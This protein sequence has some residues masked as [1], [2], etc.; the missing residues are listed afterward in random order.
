MRI[1]DGSPRQ[2]FEE[3]LRS[4]GAFLDE[5]GMRDIL[6]AET[7]DGF[8]VQALVVSGGTTGGW[9]EQLGTLTK[10]SLTLLDEDVVRLMDEG[11]ARRQG[12]A[13]AAPWSSGRFEKSLRVIGHWIDEQKPRDIFLLE[14]EGAYILRLHMNTPT[15]L[16]HVLAEFTKDDVD[17]MIAVAPSRRAHPAPAPKP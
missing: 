7:T 12:T 14:Q 17:E 3:A 2:D 1:Y 13:S 5:R 15:G 10:Q 9:S 11:R 4:I 16:K 8:F 6:I